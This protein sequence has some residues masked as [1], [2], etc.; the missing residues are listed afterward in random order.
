MPGKGGPPCHGGGQGLARASA[1]RG[2]WCGTAGHVYDPGLLTTAQHD[3]LVD[4]G[5]RY[6]ALRIPPLIGSVD[7][8]G[9]RAETGGSRK[10]YIAMGLARRRPKSDPDTVVPR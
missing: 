8:I 2:R 1:A 9:Q 5:Q 7:A 3:H 4:R 6:P 10:E